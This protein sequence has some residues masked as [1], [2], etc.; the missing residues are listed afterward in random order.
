VVA[1][2]D[3]IAVVAI[4]ISVSAFNIIVP[5]VKTAIVVITKAS[6]GTSCDFRG[7]GHQSSANSFRYSTSCNLIVI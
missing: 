5:A 7:L 2:V 1:V 4:G 6:V 3:H